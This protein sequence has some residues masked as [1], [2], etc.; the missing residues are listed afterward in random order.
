[1]V[2]VREWYLIPAAV[3]CWWLAGGV[4]HK[5][6]VAMYTMQYGL[7]TE[8]RFGLVDAVFVFHLF[9]GIFL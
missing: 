9:G 5:D 7:L 6:A 4:E 3:F 8:A 2:R 1:M